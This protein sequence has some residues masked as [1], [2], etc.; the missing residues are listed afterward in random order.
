MAELEFSVVNAIGPF[1][2][3]PGVNG[4][5][6]LVSYKLSPGRMFVGSLVAGMKIDELTTFDTVIT[7]ISWKLVLRTGEAGRTTDHVLPVNAI[8]STIPWTFVDLRPVARTIV[9][10]ARGG[11]LVL[12]FDVAGHPAG[13]QC[14]GALQGFDLPREWRKRPELLQLV[15][16]P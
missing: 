16:V 10:P 13:I 2:P 6:E 14:I 9:D 4:F 12:G 7:G 11:E 3:I 1:K 15:G 5:L 8:G